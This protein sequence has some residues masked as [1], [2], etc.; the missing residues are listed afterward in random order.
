LGAPASVP[1]VLQFRKEQAD[2]VVRVGSGEY[3]FTVTERGT[4]E[5]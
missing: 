2:Y 5:R 1:G 4:E 3:D